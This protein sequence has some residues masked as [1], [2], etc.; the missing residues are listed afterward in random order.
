[1]SRSD[2]TYPTNPALLRGVERDIGITWDND[3]LNL[4]AQ[5]AV[6][7]NNVAKI[8]QFRVITAVEVP[9]NFSPGLGLL[10]TL[11]I[12]SITKI[13]ERKNSTD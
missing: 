7:N 5:L 4:S 1:L 6:N 13:V 12:F 9:F 2:I 8:D 3:N 10:L 11:G